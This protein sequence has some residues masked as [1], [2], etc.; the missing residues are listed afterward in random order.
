VTRRSRVAAAAATLL[1]LA[2]GFPL[3]A[4]TVA[5][6]DVGASWVDYEGFLGSG[7]TYLT[8]TI[9][10]D[11]PNVTLGAS[12]SLV[13]FESG[14]HIIQF[15][16]AGGWRNRIS[17]LVYGELSG[18]A[19]VN[20]YHDFPGYGHLLA[21][22]RLHLT[23]SR[24]GGWL[25]A[26]SGRSWFNASSA[27]SYHLELGAWTAHRGF[28]VGG[29]AT[30]TWYADTN[31]LDVVGTA[32]FRDASIEITG[33]AGFRTLSEGGGEGAYGEIHAQVPIGRRFAALA[34]GGRYPS[35][36]V[37]G[38][39]AAN[40]VSAGVRV[41]I[42]GRRTRSARLVSDALLAEIEER[43][44]RYVGEARFEIE[45]STTELRVIRIVTYATESVEI[46]GDFT[47]WQPVPLLRADGNRWEI[48]WRIPAGVHR[49]NVRL[50][51]LEWIVP[52]GLRVEE[53]EFGGAV[54]ILVVGR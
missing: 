34:S 7:A 54:G 52:R 5:A 45:P 28:S 4:Q 35:D 39:I 15:L 37:R 10:H 43:E 12:G 51:G 47:D 40:Y 25:G 3:A 24:G 6:L 18:S 19:G 38:V 53:D 22:G 11:S 16:T 42:S 48:A 49:V 32:R 21:R 13:V 33:T 50:N 8:P 2:S 46:S 36:P 44:T 41:N 1:I 31:Y 27:T 20:Q 14:N 23:G 9:T 17:D 26:T 30:R 29:V